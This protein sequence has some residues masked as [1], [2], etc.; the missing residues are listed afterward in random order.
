M[1]EQDLHSHYNLTAVDDRVYKKD[2][3]QLS[4]KKKSKIWILRLARVAA[5]QNNGSHNWKLKC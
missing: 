4:G 3:N 2:M 1:L 5:V